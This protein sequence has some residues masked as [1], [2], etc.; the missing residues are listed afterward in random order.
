MIDYPLTIESYLKT[1]LEQGDISDELRIDFDGIIR[2]VSIKEIIVVMM[3]LGVINCSLWLQNKMLKI[4][5]AHADYLITF[6]DIRRTKQ[7]L[8]KFFICALSSLYELLAFFIC[9]HF[10]LFISAKALN[11][12]DT[13][14]SIDEFQSLTVCFPPIGYHLSFIVFQACFVQA[15]IVFDCIEMRTAMC[16]INQDS[17]SFTSYFFDFFGRVR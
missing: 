4:K 3:L 10:S 13:C 5:I 7:K 17:N 9:H 11:I 8:F 6:K 15:E 16:F 12:L 2:K 14:N 1:V